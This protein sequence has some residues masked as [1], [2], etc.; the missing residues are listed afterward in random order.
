MTT[1]EKFAAWLLL[2][3]G[4]AENTRAAYAH[5]V[6][7]L[8]NWLTDEGLDPRQVSLTDLHR[9]AAALMDVGIGPA[10]V[11]RILSGVRAYYTFLLTDGY[12]EQDPTELL[13]SPRRPE[14]LPT[15]LTVEE[16]DT[17]QAAIDLSRPEGRRDRAIIEVLYSCGLRVS[18]L[19]A[20]RLADLY[21]DEG[22]MRVTGKGL[23]QRLVPLSPRAVKELRLWMADRCHID[24]RPGEDDYVF[25]SHRRGK[26]LSRITVFH[27]LKLYAAQAGIGKEIS[28]HTLRHTFATH[29]LEG[30]AHLRA[31][32]AMLGHESIGTTQ[33]Y[34]H[35]DRSFLRSQILEHLP[36]NRQE[37]PPEEN[38][39]APQENAPSP[40]HNAL[41]REEN[42][43]EMAPAREEKANETKKISPI[44]AKNSA[45]SPAAPP[46]NGETGKK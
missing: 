46:R 37:T 23:K 24:I 22:F 6:D 41:A 27:N 33:L 17:L 2:E 5:D 8:L 1:N 43:A 9:F 4:L 42:V 13:E 40:E 11:A 34:T 32:Q 36:R 31:I 20:L 18:E 38:A 44:S 15:V 21:V 16:V 35:I 25:L 10:S 30:G 45:A 12:I 3:K 39:A 7:K 28:P 19:C 29:L 26:H 14:R